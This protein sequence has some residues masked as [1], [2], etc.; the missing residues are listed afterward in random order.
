MCSFSPNSIQGFKVVLIKIL[1]GFFMEL[2][3]LIL[4]HLLETWASLVLQWLGV[5]LPTQGT[6][7]Q[8]PVQGDPTCD[9]AT[10]P[11]CHNYW[12]CALEPMCPNCWG[13]RAWSRC[14]T[15]REAT[16]MRSLRTAMKSSPHLRQLERAR[17]QQRRHNA[18]KNKLI[19]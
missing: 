3:R 1:I 19:N 17:A 9:G 6:R 12:A 16:A 4:K 8:A 13:L 2:D 18:A 14:S 15:T 11:V 10:K 5:R 7:V